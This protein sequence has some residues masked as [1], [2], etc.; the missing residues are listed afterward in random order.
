M[1]L[2]ASRCNQGRARRWIWCGL[3]LLA[4]LVGGCASVSTIPS[5]GVARDMKL[6][7]PAKIFLQPFDTSDG[8]WQGRAAAAGARVEI[9]DWLTSRLET[10]LTK[11][12]PT[13]LSGS[14]PLRS[15]WLVSGRFLRVNP[16]SRV[17]RMF[18]GGVGAGASKLETKV[19]VYDVA[20]SLTEP[21]LSFTTTGGSN[22]AA[23]IPGAMSATDDDINRTA[24][25]IREFLESRLWSRGTEAAPLPPALDEIEIAPVPRGQ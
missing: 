24:R 9:R 4:V 6:R 8:M 2:E 20:V 15:G 11:I 5:E 19:E 14:E 25:E 17:K 23:G 18:L 1:Q 13:R 16:G 3:A 12:A 10:E 7:R 22:L 21:V